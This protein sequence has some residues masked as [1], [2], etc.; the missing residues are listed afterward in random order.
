[1]SAPN[2]TGSHDDDVAEIREPKWRHEPYWKPGI[3]ED[4][5]AIV[6]RVR[7]EDPEPEPLTVEDRSREALLDELEEAGWFAKKL[8]ITAADRALARLVFYT[9]ADYNTGYSAV[10][11]NVIETWARGICIGHHVDICSDYRRWWMTPNLAVDAVHEI[12]A[13]STDGQL[14]LADILQTAER[15][16]KSRRTAK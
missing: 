13:S 14:W 16:Y 9:A 6:A 12:F 3:R 7:A 11:D 8:P 2:Q 15:L 5:D 1:M 4:I 10:P